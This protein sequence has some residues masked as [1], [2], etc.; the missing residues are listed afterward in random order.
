MCGIAGFFD[1]RDR[2][3]VDGALLRCMT[4]SLIHRGP[5]ASGFFEASGP[6][7]IWSWYQIGGT[8][9]ISPIAGKF[10]EIWHTLSGASRAA[11]AFALSTVADDDLRGTRARLKAF[12][13]A[14]EANQGLEVTL[15]QTD[16]IMT[17]DEARNKG[18]Q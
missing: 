11:T 12:L 8:P 2:A 18:S 5:D 15:A 9:T 4:D 16:K 3:P 13:G 10:F 14:L 1:S 17:A 7:L 6:R